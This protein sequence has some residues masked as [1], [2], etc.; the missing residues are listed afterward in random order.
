MVP[1]GIPH[2]ILPQQPVTR[3]QELEFLDSGE[4]R[5]RL[6]QVLAVDRRSTSQSC[7]HLSGKNGSPLGPVIAPASKAELLKLLSGYHMDFSPQRLRAKGRLLPPHN[8]KMS[9]V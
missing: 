7:S 1:T 8:I 5:D 9:G 4:R 3:D 6:E 2:T